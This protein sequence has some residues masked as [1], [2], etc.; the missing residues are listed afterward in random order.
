ML[1]QVHLPSPLSVSDLSLFD[2]SHT[3]TGFL[4]KCNTFLP[5]QPLCIFE[6]VQSAESFLKTKSKVTTPLYHENRRRPVLF[7]GVK[8]WT[9]LYPGSSLSS[10]LLREQVLLAL[11]PLPATFVHTHFLPHLLMCVKLRWGSNNTRLYNKQGSLPKRFIRLLP[12]ES[13]CQ[14]NKNVIS[15]GTVINDSVPESFF[16]LNPSIKVKVW[17]QMLNE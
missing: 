15:L 5:P 1:L 17:I 4:A 8:L 10:P 13:N 14:T 3:P 12:N 16:S 6:K 7:T 9:R 2:S 11:C